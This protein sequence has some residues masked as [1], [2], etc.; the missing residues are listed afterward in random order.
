M[1]P[2]PQQ[3]AIPGAPGAPSATKVRVR[4]TGRHSP[5][6]AHTIRRPSLELFPPPSWMTVLAL[7]IV[8]VP[9]AILLVRLVVA[10]GQPL[11]LPDDLALIDLHTRRAL[12]WQQQL[13]VFD[14]NNWNHPGPTY[15]Y[16][17]SL[18]YRLVGS[19]A[20]AM[21]FGATLINALSAVGCVAVVRRRSTPARALWAAVWICF[22]AAVLATVGPGSVTYSEGA[23]GALASPWN[24]MVVIVPLLLLILLC[25][26]AMDRSPL[27]LLAAL[28]VGSFVIQTDIS[29][30]PL[31]AAL[32]V[33]SGA[34]WAA[35]L[36]VDR[37]RGSSAPTVGSAMPAT[38]DGRS[39]PRRNSHAP[40]S[41]SV[42][43]AG[44]GLVALVV[45]W[46]P[47]LIQQFTNNPGNLTLIERFFTAGNPGQSLKAGLWST[48]AA[49]GVVVEG[50][51]EIMSS[52]LGGAPHHAAAAVVASV[53]VVLVAGVVTVVG[54]RQGGR[55]AAGLGALTVVG[56]VA[57]VVSVTHVVGFVFGYLVIWAIVLPVA[58]LVSAGMVRVPWWARVVDHR[59]FTSIPAARIALCG[60]GVGLCAVLTARVVAL[61]ALGIVSDPH[62]AAMYALVTPALQ[63]HGTVFVGDA[64]A[65]GATNGLVDTEEFIGLVNRLDQSG[66]RPKV[67]HLWNVQFGPSFL[68]TGH[69]SRQVQLSTWTPTSVAVPGYRGRVG[70]MAVVVTRSAGRAGPT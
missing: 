51:S 50:P 3:R 22:L 14:R 35:T 18:A 65:G 40:N 52:L 5:S 41:R 26:A 46:L 32:L 9:F 30:L 7:T 47:P 19:G 20:K 31:V 21:F 12:H 63:P 11:Y 66:Y 13:G 64:G 34:T 15:F 67:N 49:F 55:F 69:E 6:A 54:L 1:G 60:L 28:L 53:A 57:V 61:P 43:L 45:M 23:L 42:L 4:G 44:A 56:C 37:R 16:L 24:P 27:S 38:S 59:S 62:V 10:P 25:A 58:A 70:D 17:L 39:T 33:A 48:A 29:A 2:D 8:I 68:T 36:V